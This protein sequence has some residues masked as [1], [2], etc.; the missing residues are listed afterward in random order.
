M[1]RLSKD[2]LEKE[3][4]YL[5]STFLVKKKQKTQKIDLESWFLQLHLK[6]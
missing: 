4:S 6:K 3:V 2:S 5:N 1:R